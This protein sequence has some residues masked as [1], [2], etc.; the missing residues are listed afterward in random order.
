MVRQTATANIP[1]S[2]PPQNFLSI[3]LILWW[4][5]KGKN[6]PN[7]S[8]LKIVSIGVVNIW[9][10]IKH[11]RETTLSRFIQV[12]PA[13]VFPILVS[14]FPGEDSSFFLLEICPDKSEILL[15]SCK[16]GPEETGN[17]LLVQFDV[18]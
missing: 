2:L 12:F 3:L 7:H 8:G 17:Y 1:L 9:G 15:R 14:M 6:L 4:K 13:V 5:L 16:C 11:Q 10:I 18:L